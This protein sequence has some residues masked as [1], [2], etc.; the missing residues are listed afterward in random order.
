MCQP[1]QL[2]SFP[3]SKFP[4][5]STLLS[6]YPFISSSIDNSHEKHELSVI[7][8]S[9]ISAQGTWNEL[10][11]S[12]LIEVNGVSFE[13]Q[14]FAESTAYAIT[15]RGNVELSIILFHSKK[16]NGTVFLVDIDTNTKSKFLFLPPNSTKLFTLLVSDFETPEE[17][18]I[19]ESDLTDSQSQFQDTTGIGTIPF[20][21]VFSNLRKFVISFAFNATKVVPSFTILNHDEECVTNSYLSLEIEEQS[22]GSYAL[23]NVPNFTV[24]V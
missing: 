6:T 7:S 14:G 24:F 10:D 11:L 16:S 21:L 12:K 18:P 2:S 22:S 5:L 23:K 3:P 13:K 9:H 8:I 1:T 15:N 17:T 4:L 19:N 20:K